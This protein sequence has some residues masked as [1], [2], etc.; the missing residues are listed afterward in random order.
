M[1]SFS[2][3]SNF[4]SAPS[5]VV[6]RAEE[7][8]FLRFYLEP[9]TKLMLP[10]GQVT[11]VLKIGI[12]Q[13]VPIPQ[14]PSWVMGVYNWQGNILWTIDLGHLIG[15]NSW[16]EQEISI[17]NYT[18]IVLAPDR[19]KNRAKDGE[20]LSIGLIVTRVEDI[21][22]CDTSLIQSPPAEAVTPALA[23]FLQGYWLKLNGEMILTL[24]GRAIIEAMPHG[25]V[26]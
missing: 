10:I 17:S 16:Y 26:E 20:T 22:W 2:S 19:K 14:M 1:S 13:I 3:Q 12:G 11:E 24:D 15:L 4:L 5:I 25:E 9:E 23:P 6:G 8:Q 18:A 7:K 21:E